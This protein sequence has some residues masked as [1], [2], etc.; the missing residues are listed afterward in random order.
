MTT[1][2]HLVMRMRKMK[3]EKKTIPRDMKKKKPK[4]EMT[5]K[6]NTKRKTSKELPR[7]PLK[8]PTKTTLAIPKQKLIPE[9][10]DLTPRRRICDSMISQN[11]FN[12]HSD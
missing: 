6:M 3:R 1:T 10:S 8:K 9:K 4:T 2:K 7:K 12:A 5:V 11:S